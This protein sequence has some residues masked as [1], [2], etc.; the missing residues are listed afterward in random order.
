VAAVDAAITQARA[1]A[2]KPTLIICKTT[3][4]K[5]S[6]KPCR[7]RQ[8]AWRGA[9]GDEIKLNREALGWPH[10]PFVIPEAAY[11]AWDGKRAGE[12]SEAMVGRQAFA[13]YKAEHPAL[14]TELAR[15]NERRPAGG[16]AQAAVDA[17][18]AAPQRRP[19]GR[20]PQGQPDRARGFHRGRL[21][22]C[23]ADR[24]T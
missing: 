11:A 15:R 12:A 17:A 6:P 4:G 23:W 13:A 1:E 16:F 9:G 8:G 10:E 18:V 20:Q 5:G 14:A 3:I 24:P 21:P 2:L 19:D 7:Q 22:S